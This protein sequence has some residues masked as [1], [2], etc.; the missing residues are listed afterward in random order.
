MSD[1]PTEIM[2]SAEVITELL[3]KTSDGKK[4]LLWIE[5]QAIV[6]LIAQQLQYHL[7]PDN[8]SKV[9]E[10]RLLKPFVNR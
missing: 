9:G 5:L 3:S 1:P 6:Q 8:S 2:R 10:F 4:L 7:D